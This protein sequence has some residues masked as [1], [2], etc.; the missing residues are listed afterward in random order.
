MHD[1]G[2]PLTRLRLAGAAL[3]ACAA[4]L[5]QA[6]T[7]LLGVPPHAVQLEVSEHLQ[8][9]HASEG[10][11][12]TAYLDYPSGQPLAPQ[13]FS[14][15]PSVVRVVLR[16]LGPGVP[17]RAEGL[18]DRALP[19]RSEQEPGRPWFVRRTPEGMVV[20]RL[21]T[22]EAWT[23]S[24]DDGAVVAVNMPG[25]PVHQ[26]HLASRR[27]GDS[28]EVIYQYSREH[29]DIRAMDAF[30]LAQLRTHVRSAVRMPRQPGPG[31]PA[32]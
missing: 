1:R 27:Y 14:P 15:G 30:V 12:L 6:A 4:G 8:A 29:T 25:T 2:S 9:V 24:G 22:Q 18:V 26:T 28:L 19:A 16:L 21:V 17:S 11:L 32:R 7:F 13:T 10:D 23:F 20:Y 5:A 3:F 31:L